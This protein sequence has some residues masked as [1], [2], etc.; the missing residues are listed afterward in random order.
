MHP[1][2]LFLHRPLF[3]SLVDL[4]NCLNPAAAQTLKQLTDV[5]LIPRDIPRLP[6]VLNVIC[7]ALD[8]YSATLNIPNGLFCLVHSVVVNLRTT[9]TEELGWQTSSHEL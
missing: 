5:L 4:E 1:N 8:A 3:T 9:I 7:Q 6:V 2:D